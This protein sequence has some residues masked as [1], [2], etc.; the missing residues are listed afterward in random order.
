M[1]EVFLETGEPEIPE[2]V[3]PLLGGFFRF[4]PKVH[5]ALLAAFGVPRQADDVRSPGQA[6][7]PPQGSNFRHRGTLASRA[8][9][10]PRT[11]FS[12]KTIAPLLS[13][14][15]TRICAVSISKDFVPAGRPYFNG[16]RRL[17]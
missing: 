17:I 3:R 4:E 13:R 2:A 16:R 10:R 5:V 11:I 12:R 1:A 14:P 9:I 7:I 6:D 15:M 8:V